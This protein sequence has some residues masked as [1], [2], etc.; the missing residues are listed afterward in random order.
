M[1]RNKQHNLEAGHAACFTD[2]NLDG[3]PMCMW[4]TILFQTTSAIS[5]NK[6]GTFYQPAWAKYFRHTA[7][8]AMGTDAADII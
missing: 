2:I 8:N 4:P 1:Y 3:C 5:N 6:D 7:W